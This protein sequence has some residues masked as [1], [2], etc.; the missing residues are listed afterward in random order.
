MND[1]SV[2]E[3]VQ[4]ILSDFTSLDSAQDLFSE[5]NYYPTED[6]LSRD[7]LNLSAQDALADDPLVIAEY[8]G[9]QIIYSRLNSNKLSI[10]RERPV[11]NSLLK[12]HP[13][14][15][16]LFSNDDK[17]LWHFVNVKYDTEV[18]NRRIFR[19][20]TVDPRQ[21][22]MRTA[23]DRI[24][25]LEIKYIEDR[26]TGFSGARIQTGHDDAFDVEKVTK[27]FF[28]DFKNVFYSIQY[29]IRKIPEN[30][31]HL[32]TQQ[33]C[34][35]LLFLKFLEQKRWLNGD[36]DYLN[37]LFKKSKRNNQNFYREYL[38]YLFFYALNNQFD[39]AEFVKQEP[40]SERLGDI[41]FLNGG[42]FEL[43]NDWNDKDIK[44]DNEAFTK[45]L[46]F[47]NHYN[48]T[49]TE[50]T[51]L[52]IEVAVD[53]ELLGKVFEEL[54]TGRH[55]TGSYYTPK[56]VVS[57][58]CR[59]A[60]KGYLQTA[61]PGETK[62][63][64]ERF[65]DDQ[66]TD[67][68]TNPE[69]VLDAL[70]TVK[71]CDPACGSGAYL[72]GMMHEL[73]FLREC[74]FA[75]HGLDSITIYNRKLEI[76]QNSIYGVDIDPF[77][78]NIAR[79]RL[80]LSLAVD[81]EGEKPEPLPNLDFKIEAGDSLLGPNPT[82]GGHLRGELVS[83]YAAKKAEYMRTHSS[84]KSE[85]WKEIA[86]MKEEIRTWTGTPK[87]IFDWL[88]EF[89]EVFIAKPAGADITDGLNLGDHLAPLHETGGFDIVI[90]NPPYVRQELLKEYKPILRN[91]Q[92]SVFNSTSDLYTYFYERSYQ[93]IKPA[94]VSCFISSNKWQRAKYGE[95]LRHFFR[96]NTRV[97]MLIDFGGYQ[98]FG[99]TVDTNIV[100]FQKKADPKWNTSFVNVGK[101]FKVDD[102]GD[103]VNKNRQKIQQ[104][105][106]S[107]SGWTLAGDKVL[108]LKKKIERA[109]FVNLWL[110]L[111]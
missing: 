77:A 3:N 20:I 39:N 72:L 13:L 30:Y 21:P 69:A 31:K 49:V 105:E 66:N 9:F 25:M 23:V 63:G 10:T 33:L 47:F 65:L 4:S 53:P 92:Y 44:I 91:L 62:E 38:Y 40:L 99:A 88:V 101:D 79:L 29:N 18:K 60:L 19:R 108:R 16:F 57:F 111:V 94:G 73:L 46:G 7:D 71:A 67:D 8:E 56:Q 58:M 12:D 104:Q 1:L 6:E 14:S 28:H 87:E 83:K 75:K 95:K 97:I 41:P 11:I 17:N 52:D 34:N 68:L 70:K 43:S 86:I 59:E 45:L 74:L 26:F 90:A 35:R 78:V 102:I 107:D 103:H 96:A 54:V 32:F 106:L 109:V 98:V 89:T 2:A 80:W 110:N 61:L 5:L 22:Y 55:E 100:L 64:I 27:D 81:F 50:S 42:L 82:E 76:I 24:S 85:L 48:F 15:L 93:I 36:Y 51:P 37:S 84:Q